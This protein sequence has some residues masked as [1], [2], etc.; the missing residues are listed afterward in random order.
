MEKDRASFPT[1]F[2][3]LDLLILQISKGMPVITA[4]GK[5]GNIQTLSDNSY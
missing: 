3:L 2:D 1:S 5:Q 4:C